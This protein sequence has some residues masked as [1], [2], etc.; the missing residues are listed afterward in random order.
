[1]QITNVAD[2]SWNCNDPRIT[3][4]SQVPYYSEIGHWLLIQG[5]GDRKVCGR[6]TNSL[7]EAKC[8]GMIHVAGSYI[9]PTP[10]PIPQYNYCCYSESDCP[11]VMGYLKHCGNFSN[12]CASGKKCVWIPIPTS[13]PITSTPTPRPTRPPPRV[14]PY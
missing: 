6:F 10:T 13:T 11:N 1:M 7:G 9:S 12:Y 3:W 8:G 5:P 2:I 4:G 14:T